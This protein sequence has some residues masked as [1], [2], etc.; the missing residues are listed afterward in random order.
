[1]PLTPQIHDSGSATGSPAVGPSVPFTPSTLRYRTCWRRGY[2]RACRGLAGGL[3]DD[4]GHRHAGCSTDGTRPGD[5]V[6]VMGQGLVGL[7]VTA[8]L[9]ANGVRVMGVTWLLTRK[10]IRRGNGRG[11]IRAAGRSESRG[12]GPRMDRRLRSGRSGACYRDREQLSPR[13]Q[14]IE[15]LRD[16]GAADRGGNTRVDLAWKT[17]YEK[18]IEVRYTRSYGPGR[19][20]SSYE[21]GARTIRSGTCAGPSS[22]TSTPAS[23]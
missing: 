11:A 3:H 6:L 8:L 14:A 17:A 20:D 19:Y 7:L 12:R 1:M 15:V 5:R 22:A 21:W 9:R 2:R 10:P 13:E 23:T 16:R 4:H 18:E